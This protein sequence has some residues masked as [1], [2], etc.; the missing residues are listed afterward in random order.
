M[1]TILAGIVSA[2][3]GMMIAAGMFS[4]LTTSRVINRM[5]HVT[6]ISHKIRVV[7]EVIMFGAILGNIAFVFGIKTELGEI[8]GDIYMMLAG[9]FTGAILVALAEVIKA[10][11]VFI[12]RVRISSGFGYVI[13]SFAAGKVFGSIIESIV[14]VS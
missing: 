9:M 10:I 7:E 13:L 6:Y 14:N 3:G 2:C 1:K 4:L 8:I 12:R 11:P 5:L